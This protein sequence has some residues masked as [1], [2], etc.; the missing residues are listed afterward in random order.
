MF[1]GFCAIWL[2]LHG[3]AGARGL[4]L[5]TAFLFVIVLYNV[6]IYVY[7]SCSVSIAEKHIHTPIHSETKV[8]YSPLCLQ[9]MPVTAYFCLTKSKELITAFNLSSLSWPTPQGRVKLNIE[10]ALYSPHTY[11]SQR[12][13]ICPLVV[14]CGICHTC[15]HLCACNLR[16]LF[17]FL[18][19]FH[20]TRMLSW[21]GDSRQI[22]FCLPPLAIQ[23]YCVHFDTTRPKFKP[24]R[25]H[26][27]YYFYLLPVICF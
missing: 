8:M 23:L 14:D 7:H 13:V 10:S 2:R 21:A 17:F 19:N 26:F 9:P 6:Y 15:L 20:D 1:G 18:H 4:T 27:F 24:V 22:V 16:S 5:F 25:G 11:P 12:I 3:K